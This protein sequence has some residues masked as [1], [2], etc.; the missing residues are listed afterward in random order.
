MSTKKI[1]EAYQKCVNKIDDFLEYD[2]VNYNREKVRMII[3]NH[4][5]TLTKNLEEITN[6]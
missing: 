6:D 1:L 3:L 4:I 2:Y 5:I